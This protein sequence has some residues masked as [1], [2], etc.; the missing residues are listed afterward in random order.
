MDTKSEMLS[1]EYS[2]VATVEWENS[3]E[4]GLEQHSSNPSPN[5]AVGGN[6]AQDPTHSVEYAIVIYE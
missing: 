6:D 1:E 2:D 5:E 4:V 3:V